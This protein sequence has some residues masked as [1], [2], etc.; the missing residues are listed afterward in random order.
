MPPSC[1][2][3]GMGT[4]GCACACDA[5]WTTAADQQALA[6]QGDPSAV[7]CSQAATSAPPGPQP[8]CV[9]RGRC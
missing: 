9:L 4:G 5:G 8:A 2:G 6:T 7:F 1:G 3:H